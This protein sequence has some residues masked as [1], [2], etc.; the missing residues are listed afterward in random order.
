MFD[1]RYTLFAIVSKIALLD[2][3]LFATFS[4]S[5]GLVLGICV[6]LR[7]QAESR[8]QRVYR[9]VLVELS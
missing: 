6:E 1:L 8:G 5:R 3:A 4:L 9:L 7:H 2:I